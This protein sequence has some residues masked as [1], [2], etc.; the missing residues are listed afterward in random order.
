MIMRVK[1]D[2]TFAN[3]AL[4]PQKYV[5]EIVGPVEGAGSVEVDLTGGR[6]VQQDFTVTPFLSL[7]R[8]TIL[9]GVEG[10]QVTVNYGITENNGRQAQIR[11]VYC[12]TVNYPNANTGNGPYWHTR[13]VSLEENN[14]TVTISDLT[15]GT[16][17]FLRVGARADGTN[18]FNFSETISFDTP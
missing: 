10:T 13:R 11:E 7:E 17:Y 9:G 18:A 1:G 3:T 15:P 6:Q 14:G 8:P 2:G 12:S 16:K 5:I 4:F